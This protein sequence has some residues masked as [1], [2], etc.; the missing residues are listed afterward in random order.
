M[1]TTNSCLILL[2]T[3][4]AVS[5]TRGFLDLVDEKTSVWTALNDSLRCGSEV[6]AEEFDA[7]EEVLHPMWQS[8]PVDAEGFIEFRSLRYLVYRYFSQVSSLRLRGF[9][10]SDVVNTS[11]WD[12]LELSQRVPNFVEFGLGPGKF[13]LRD[14][15][16]YIAA[17]QQII[18]NADSVILEKVIRDEGRKTRFSSGD[19]TSILDKYVLHWMGGDSFD[20]RCFHLPGEQSNVCFDVPMKRELLALVRAQVKGLEFRRNHGF[21][22]SGRG[23]LQRTFSFSDLHVVANS[24]TKNF[25]WFYESDCTHMQDALIQIDTQ[26]TGRI[27]LS[28]FYAA[29]PFFAESEEYLSAQGVLDSSV[30]SREVQVIIPNYVQAS[31]NCIVATA[32]YHIC[33]PNL[34]ERLLGELEVAVRS[35]SA[36]VEDILAAVDE[37]EEEHVRIGGSLRLRLTEVSLRHGGQVRLHSRLFAQWLHYVFPHECPFPHTAGTVSQASAMEYMGVVEV[38]NHVREEMAAKSG[39]QASEHEDSIDWMSLWNEDE[40]L[41][42]G[43]SSETRSMSECR[44]FVIV[45]GGALL[46]CAG[47]VI[48]KKPATSFVSSA[49]KSHWV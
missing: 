28:K 39:L 7:I 29:S 35:A 33:C 13:T 37:M 42:A 45:L 3:C 11:S 12:V 32:Q 23:V 40:E 18:F 24:I 8:M 46:L 30:S 10:P 43:Y 15:V 48:R 4:G 9:E 38:A 6:Q 34:C 1:I 27:P 14:G 21:S 31:S 5:G 19:L 44:N 22:Q 36:T 17:L 49:P 20:G 16:V 25:A 26:R 47:R 2:A 41:L